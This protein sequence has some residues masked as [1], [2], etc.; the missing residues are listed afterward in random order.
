MAKLISLLKERH[1]QL[2]IV[3][4][5]HGA[6]LGI[7]TVG[8][9]VSELMDKVEIDEFKK[10]EEVTILEDGRIRIPGSFKLHRA[11]KILGE[12]PDCEVD[13]VNGL[14]IHILGKSS[15]KRRHCRT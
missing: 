11:T 12:I 5:E 13:T 9:L 2:A 3:V 15:E 6:T 1:S 10:P 14:V 8:D 4:D 7:V